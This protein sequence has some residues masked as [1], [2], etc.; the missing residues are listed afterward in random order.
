MAKIRV[1]FRVLLGLV[2]FGF[3]LAFFLN[4]LPKPDNQSAAMVEFASALFNTG[5]FFQ[6]L[7]G[8][9]VVGGALLL[10]NLF[11]PLALVILAPITL[12]I[13][14]IHVFLE[15][16]G[17]PVALAMTVVHVL[18]GLFYWPKFRHLFDSKL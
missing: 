10:V 14:L 9:E 18:L 15:P 3:G 8:T 11:T 16:S 7:K 12:N 13:L 1:L 17:L 6:M 5:Y 2:Y 4:L